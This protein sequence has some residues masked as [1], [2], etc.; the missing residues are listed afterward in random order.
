M[1]AF[2]G[3]D[4]TLDEPGY[5]QMGTNTTDDDDSLYAEELD[6]VRREDIGGSILRCVDIHESDLLSLDL[7]RDDVGWQQLTGGGALDMSASVRTATVRRAR[8]YARHDG[9]IKQTIA[10][11]TNFAVGRG[12][13]WTV[14]ADAEQAHEILTEFTESK[15]NRNL[16]S[17]QG[18]RQSSDELRQDGEVFFTLFPAGPD[19][20]K[21]RKLDPL[22]IV[23]ILTNPEDRNEPRLYVR[24]YFVGSQKRTV[25]YRDWMWDGI[26]D[27]VNGENQSITGELQYREFMTARA[28]VARAIAMFPY[29]LKLLAD[30]AGLSSVKTQLGTG[31]TESSSETNPPAVPGSMFLENAGAT[32]SSMKQETGANAAKVDAEL[33]MQQVGVGSGIFPHYYGLGNSFR[34]AT[35]DSMEP[36]MFKAFEAYQELWRD[37]YQL[38]FEWVLEQMSVPEEQRVVTVKGE[39]IRKQDVGPLIDGAEKAVRSFPSLADSTELAKH[40]LTL[41]G[42][43]DPASVIDELTEVY[44]QIPGHNVRAMIH[45]VLQEVIAR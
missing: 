2:R 18:Q 10:L 45:K 9:S 38:L 28:A 39:P 27:A 34:L 11:Y 42:V 41:L 7:I 22:E 37:T 24:R 14:A 20:P 5:V 13:T 8:Q 19:I 33:F 6:Q 23:D 25:L 15:W 3:T 21:V 1:L 32:L 4:Q 44:K 36:P 26:G 29:K 31:L 30:A 12:F 16:F 40:V 17:T 43:T 35:A